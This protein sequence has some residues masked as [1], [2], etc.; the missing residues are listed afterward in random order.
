MGEGGGCEGASFRQSLVVNNDTTD[1][2]HN[3][4]RELSVLSILS[5]RVTGVSAFVADNIESIDESTLRELSKGA[6]P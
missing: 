3:S 4:R 2:Y 1:S 5:P 6:M